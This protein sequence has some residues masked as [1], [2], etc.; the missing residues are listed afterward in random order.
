[1][2][3]PKTNRNWKLYSAAPRRGYRHKPRCSTITDTGTAVHSVLEIQWSIDT[4]NNTLRALFW[5]NKWGVYLASRLAEWSRWPRQPLTTLSTDCQTAARNNELMRCTTLLFKVFEVPDHVLII[6][7]NGLTN[8]I[9]IDR[10]TPV[11]FQDSNE[12]LE[13]KDSR[14]PASNFRWDRG[15][16]L[17]IQTILGHLQASS[18]LQYQV[19]WY[20]NEIKDDKFEPPSNIPHHSISLY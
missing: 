19:Q 5:T 13:I 14:L 15:D 11:G 16:V 17:V 10:A 12:V 20:G 7:E 2:T 1:M 9:W 8:T 3:F 6:D 4:I 18:G